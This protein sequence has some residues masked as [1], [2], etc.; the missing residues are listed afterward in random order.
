MTTT[1]S[2]EIQL[3]VSGQ[4]A[5]I[6]LDAP[7][8]RNAITP[9]MARS[10]LEA[11]ESVS[12]DPSVAALVIA[13]VGE[14]F[15]AGA[16]LA[17][18]SSA[19]AD[20]ASNGTY[21]DI[22]VIYQAFIALTDVP[23]PV[24]AAVHGPAIGA[25][26][27]L[28]LSA[29]LRIVAHD[30]RLASAFVGLGVHPGGAHFSLLTRLV[31]REAAMAIGLF[32]VEIEG[33]RAVEMGLAWESVEASQVEGRALEMAQKLSSDPLL[34][35]ELTA[36]FRGETATAIP[37]RLAVQAERASQMWSFRRKHDQV[38]PS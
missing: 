12:M 35:R 5:V 27:N 36:T 11:I 31:G 38:T 20:P 25:G 19:G 15:C 13:G 9:S 1:R 17:T 29:D 33:R 21:E 37:L 6:R 23:I 14:A 28:A 2:G 34:S 4:L 8:R 18:L 30:A 32:G 7:E 24:I 22:G 16:D 10:M 3:E 26:L